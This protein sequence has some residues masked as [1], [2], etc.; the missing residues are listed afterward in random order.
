MII[1]I[2][3]LQIDGKRFC[4]NSVT[5]SNLYYGTPG[6]GDALPGLRRYEL[7]VG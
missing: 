2:N 6:G 4:E 7:E 1:I 3:K 5:G